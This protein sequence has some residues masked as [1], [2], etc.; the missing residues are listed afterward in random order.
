MWPVATAVMFNVV[1]LKGDTVFL[2]VFGSQTEVGL[3][4]AAYR[5]V[6]ILSQ[7]AMMVMGVMLPLMA[8]AWAARKQ[9]ELQQYVQQGFDA[10]ML[11]AVPVTIG[12]YV[13]ATPIIVLVAGPDFVRAGV[14]LTLLALAIFGV[15]VGAIFGHIAVAINKQKETLP[16]YI[17]NAIITLIGYSIIIPRYGMIGAAI[18]TIFSEAYTG[19]LLY[20]TIKSYL[21]FRIAG[22]VYIKILASGAIM[23][24]TIYLLQDVFHVVFVSAIGALIYAVSIL[25]TRAISRQTIEEIIRIKR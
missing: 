2:S 6:D 19:I 17:S 12:V 9:D 5:V 14:P 15:Y 1:Y 10:M 7:L 18:M 3:Y 24:W 22:R 20:A 4:G 21:P 8:A 13:L 16:I 25:A 23:G 11:F